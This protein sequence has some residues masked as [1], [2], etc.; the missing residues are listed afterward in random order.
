MHDTIRKGTTMTRHLFIAL[1]IL[2]YPS[3]APALR[4]GAAEDVVVEQLFFGRNMPGGQV[5]SD[6]AWINFLSEVVTPRF[7]DGLTVFQAAGQWRGA[8]GKIE[9]EASFVLD[10][11][12]CLLRRRIRISFSSYRNTSGVFSRR[13]CCAWSS[14]QK[15]RIKWQADLVLD[16]GIFIYTKRIKGVM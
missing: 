13:R 16:Q 6:S 11:C 8:D 2:T 5:V 1:V 15:H 4:T 9:R 14:R 10:W 7:P 3:C 12:T